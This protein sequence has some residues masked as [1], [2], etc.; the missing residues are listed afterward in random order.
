MFTEKFHRISVTFHNRKQL[1]RAISK[2]KNCSTLVQTYCITMNIFICADPLV[3]WDSDIG[4][5]TKDWVHDTYRSNMNCTQNFTGGTFC[6]A[7]TR[8]TKKNMERQRVNYIKTDLNTR[9]AGIPYSVKCLDDWGLITG[10]DEMI[11]LRQP[12]DRLRT[13]PSG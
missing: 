4:K 2:T 11:P 10:R 8:N 12:W 9:W 13:L 5:A 6:E 7:T 3:M 1:Q